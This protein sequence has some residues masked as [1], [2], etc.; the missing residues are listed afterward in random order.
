MG[1]I[2]N[3]YAALRGHGPAELDRRDSLLGGGVSV[4]TFPS[5]TGGWNAWSADS[6]FGNGAK[7][8]SNSAVAYRCISMLANNAAS[9]PLVVRG[10]DGDLDELHPL[11]QLWNVMP[12]RTMPAQVLKSLAMTRLQL[13]G[14]CHLWL[15]YNGR[16][17]V[18]TPDEIWYVYDRVT[19]IVAT[20]AA[21]A[22]PQ[23]Q[24]IGYV[25]ER[26]DGV[27]VPVLAEEML[28]L[29]FS[30]P[31]DPL[32]VMAP[33]KA[34]RSAVDAD[35]YAA[36]WQRQ[37]FKNGAR[38]GGV[39][40]LG[41]M[42]ETTFNR[43]VAAFR[44]QVEGVQNAGRHLLIA[45]QGSDGGTAGK[46]ATFTSLSM[47]P[48]EMDYI[49]SRM[50]SAE[51]VMLAFGVRRDALLGGSTY[52]NQAEAKAA[53]WTETLI[54]QMEVMASITDLQLLPDIGWTV[55]FDFNSVPALQED[56]E[57]QAGRNQGYLVNDVLMVDEAR[58]SIGLDP[59]PGGIG[60][61]TLTPYRAQ[62]TPAPAPAP[63]A[64]E[65]AARMLA[66]LER[67]A[68]DRPLPEL[69]A[70][71]TTVLHHDPGPDPQQTL[72]ERLEALLQPLLVELGRRQA[73]V[74][75]REFDLLMRGE[76]AA[77]LW[78]ADVR[79]VAGEAYE[80]GALL[81]PPDAEEV[82]PA[83]LTRLDLAPEDLAVRINVKRI[84]NARKWVSRTKETL[85]GW[86]ETAWRTGGDHV[87]AQLGDGFDLDEQVL[88]ELDKRLDV[89]AGQINQT[90]EAALRAQLLHHGVQQGESVD[91]LRARLQ[92]VF[93]D[94]T[95]WRAQMIARTET[96]GAFNAAGLVAAERSGATSKTW[97]ATLD[98]RTRASHRL[99]NG[100]TVPLGDAFDAVQSR[101][102]GD[103]A[104]PAS[105]SINCRCT[106]TYSKES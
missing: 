48:A 42:D 73:A 63:A 4:T 103:P 5:G 34:A 24:I 57:A 97:L 37:S 44:S 83:R 77:A 33:W 23:A 2:R 89:L 90:T 3:A 50:H 19:T 29:R 79:A 82:P 51:E 8:W 52:E 36:T 16:A 55:E 31:Y 15:N 61:M 47:S 40:N 46:G 43:T 106:L 102:P 60:Q 9:V 18:G 78:L 72:Y 74:T 93:T 69:P 27:R 66:L 99:E 21:D 76:R 85:R 68:A 88:A 6:I 38:P 13:D 71:A 86:Y 75:L 94:L 26:T 70:R 80:R 11:S 64:E 53:V 98:S 87:G 62:F 20:R 92:K 10:P 65:G 81:A 84:F 58:A 91:E 54:P 45:G 105:Q 14:Q 12:N 7:G 59:L 25:I 100:K 95:D 56:L 39:V 22:V 1:R 101:W 104:A 67:V 41:D 28:W 96:V 49:N 35:F 17:P 30:D 32:A